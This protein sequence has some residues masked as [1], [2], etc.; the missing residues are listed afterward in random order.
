MAI[1][2]FHASASPPIDDTVG[3]LPNKRF[4]SPFHESE[5]NAG[6]KEAKQPMSTSKGHCPQAG[7]DDLASA[8]TM[9]PIESPEFTRGNRPNSWPPSFEKK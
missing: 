5:T 2:P 3:P 1:K 7:K 6:L 9:A 4:G 8:S